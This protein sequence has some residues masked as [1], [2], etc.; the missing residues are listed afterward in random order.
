MVGLFSITHK[1]DSDSDT[2]ISTCLAAFDRNADSWERARL[3]RLRLEN[4]RFVYRLSHGAL[5]LAISQVRGMAPG[6]VTLA[7]EASGKPVCIDGPNFSLSHTLDLTVIA[8]SQADEVGIDVEPLDAL[9]DDH[10]DLTAALSDEDRALLPRLSQVRRRAETMI[11]TVKEAALK[12]TGDVMF[13]PTDLAVT[14]WRDLFRVS[15]ARAARAP[16]PDI[17]VRILPLAQGYV[18][19]LATYQPIPPPGTMPWPDAASLVFETG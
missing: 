11:W 8:L 3:A 1:S 16:C 5:R 9:P 18:T 6:A 13:P 15:S 4:D 2:L 10:T 19:A 7:S 17:F 14:P 12:L